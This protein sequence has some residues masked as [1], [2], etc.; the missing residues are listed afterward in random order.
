MTELTLDKPEFKQ[1]LK[2]TIQ[3]LIQEEREMFSELLVQALEDIAME[4]TIKEGENSEVVSH[5]EIFKM[6]T[7]VEKAQ[8]LFRQYVPE[9][10]ILSEE[11]MA[12]RRQEN[13]VE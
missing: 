13:R 9:G 7:S 4:N 12:E 11:L 8:D 1:L 5:D 10:R 6:L 2:A 3:E